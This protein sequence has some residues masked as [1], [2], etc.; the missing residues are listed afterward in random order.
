MYVY[1]YIC[2]Y[3]CVYI[4]MYIYIYI[5]IH[6]RI[7]HGW[8]YYASNL[9]FT[10]CFTYICSITTIVIRQT[11]LRDLNR[12]AWD[13]GLL[14]LNPTRMFVSSPVSKRFASSTWGTFKTNHKWSSSKGSS[15]NLCRFPIS[16]GRDRSKRT[17]DTVAYRYL[18]S[19]YVKIAIEHGPVEIVDF[20]INSMVIFHSYVN[21]YQ[22][23]HQA[24]NLATVRCSWF[25]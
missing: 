11:R 9:L 24:S 17:L 19:G 8:K 6:T 22:R 12:V 20:P 25:P 16:S 10:T 5:Y 14:R 13:W 1:I 21:V 2:I 18:T 15:F 3:I 4:Y 23:V 7:Y